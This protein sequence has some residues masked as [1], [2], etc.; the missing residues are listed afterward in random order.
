LHH[1]GFHLGMQP[2]FSRNFAQDI[3]Q[4]HM[5]R[6]S[7][8][9]T[10]ALAA[11]AASKLQ[12]LSNLKSRI[13]QDVMCR[14]GAALLPLIIGPHGKIMVVFASTNSCECEGCLAQEVHPLWS[15][16]FE[17][18]PPVVPGFPVPASQIAAQ[19]FSQAFMEELTW[20]DADDDTFAWNK[21]IVEGNS[22]YLFS[23]NLH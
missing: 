6:S 5:E 10:M 22:V 14:L 11:D 9:E 21:A 19:A 12:H 20:N 8:I 4:L 1:F 13:H 16:A 7:R 23:P 2:S 17:V 3:I 15:A 18:F